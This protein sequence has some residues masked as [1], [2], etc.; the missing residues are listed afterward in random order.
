MLPQ[1][2]TKAKKP[3][4][5]RSP[6][7][8]NWIRG[9]HCANCGVSD[10]IEAAHVR[11]LGGGGMGFKPADFDCVPLCK[12]CHQEQHSIGERTFWTAYQAEHGQSVHELVWHLQKASPKAREIKDAKRECTHG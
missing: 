11:I 2:K 10:P 12:N 3:K 5:W 4:R 7:H 1:R 6:A 9:F 8:L